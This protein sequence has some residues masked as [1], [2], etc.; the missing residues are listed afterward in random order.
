MNALEAFHA[1]H[2]ELLDRICR[3]KASVM[4]VETWTTVK[5]RVEIAELDMVYEDEMDLLRSY[6]E[7]WE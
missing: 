2:V 3:A 7:V 1:A 6:Y 4:R 5:Q